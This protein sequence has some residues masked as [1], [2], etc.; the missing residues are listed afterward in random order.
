[1]K[2][3][4]IMVCV[5][6]ISLRV[7]SQSQF[8]PLDPAPKSFNQLKIGKI[9]W[10]N[11][12][13]TLGVSALSYP[14]ALIFRQQTGDTAHYYSNGVKWMKIGGA[15]NFSTLVKYT[16]T[17][18]MLTP[19]LRKADTI[20]LSSRID[21][22]A[23]ITGG[24]GYIQNQ[25]AAAQTANFWLDGT[26]QGNV[27]RGNTRLEA[28]ASW[29]ITGN[30]GS[31][32]FSYPSGS[33]SPVTISSSGNT[34]FDGGVTMEN[35]NTTMDFGGT[36]SPR[37]MQF[38]NFD[39]VNQLG[40]TSNDL[41][42]FDPATSRMKRLPFAS[43]FGA[44]ELLANKATTLAGANNTTYPT[45]LAVANSLAGYAP[46][47]GSGNYIQ[48]QFSAAQAG[49]GWIDGQFRVGG[50]PSNGYIHLNTAVG[51]TGW[52]GFYK[53]DNTRLGYIG[54]NTTDMSYVAEN[55]ARHAFSG[56]RMLVNAPTD[57]GS[58]AVQINGVIKTNNDII[59]TDGTIDARLTYSPANSIAAIGSFSNHALGI[60]INA[61]ERMRITSAGNVGIGT[62]TPQAPL[63][64]Q[65]PNGLGVV[66]GNNGNAI[67][68]MN[69]NA[70]DNLY[71]NHFS[72]GNVFMGT[73]GGKVGI[74]TTT[75]ATTLEINGVAT[76]PAIYSPS[77]SSLELR[78]ASDYIVMSQGGAGQFTYVNSDGLGVGGFAGGTHSAKGFF[79]GNVVSTD[80]FIAEGGGVL[81][82]FWLGTGL[83]GNRTV[84][85]HPFTFST[86]S[87]E[88]ARFTA[89][90]NLLI[91]TTTDNSTLTL[92]GSFAVKTRTISTATPFTVASDDHTILMEGMG[93]GAA[94]GVLITLPD[95]ATCPGRIL[96]FHE[97]S[98]SNWAINYNISRPNAA[99][100]TTMTLTTVIQSVGGSW[101]LISRN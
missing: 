59:S 48:T 11:T 50:S 53:P 40:T 77:G 97:Y 81:A 91:N 23:P 4:L 99:A 1:M 73:G 52:V 70:Y 32:T 28:S 56:G 44:Y 8:P 3:L 74:N 87:L 41:L 75:P 89:G 42:M 80:A 63:H 61:I 58:S 72:S 88:R 9:F 90:G 17:A 93:T 98:A 54:S 14:G 69:G 36:V 39:N 37:F 13:D 76:A 85:N 27:L 82:E 25:N 21:G 22:K 43:A 38:T 15:P 60:Y 51:A 7:F 26:G 29:H 46:V 62:I 96:H 35:G 94:D 65:N 57:D 83:A 55:G 18:A 47:S 19:Y 64:V 92:N 84:S 5:L 71:I 68:G 16:D 12:N 31:L 101:R 10:I 49:N 95:P 79:N 24:T 66:I 30:S 45:T 86:N 34:N 33:R 100:L 2:R 67:D 78:A 6:L 20:Y